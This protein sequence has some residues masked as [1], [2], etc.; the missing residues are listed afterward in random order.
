MKKFIAIIAA[1]ALIATM[2]VSVFAENGTLNDVVDPAVLSASKAVKATYA[3]TGADKVDEIHL[4]ITWTDID[5]TYTATDKVWNED[6]M[7]WED[8]EGEWTDGAAKVAVSSRSSVEVTVGAAY[9]ADGVAA[10]FDKASIDLAAADGAAVNGEFNL[11]VDP[12]AEIVE[13]DDTAGTITITVA[14]A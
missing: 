12:N 10:T 6:D 2:S 9:V 5:F 11:T 14:A 13:T 7:V 1:I 3:D 8:S 4:D